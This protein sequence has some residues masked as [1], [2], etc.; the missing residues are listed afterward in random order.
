M[1]GTV[2]DPPLIEEVDERAAR[3]SVADT[4]ADI[5]R[6]LGVPMVVFVYR[7][8][9]ATT[10]RLERVWKLLAPNLASVEAQRIAATLDPPG[11]WKITPLPQE[12][13]EG[14]GIGPP[15]LASTLD[16]F[17]RANRLNL[18]G[19]QALLDGTL[20]DHDADRREAPS[21][22]PREVL[23]IADLAALEPDTIALL[24]RMSAPVAGSEQPILIPSLYRYF[25]HDRDLLETIWQSI[26]PAV[27]TE[28]FHDV[29]AAI[30]A[31]AR[32][33]SRRLPYAVP[34]ADDRGTRDI[35]TR[36]VTTIPGMI[37]TTKL[38]RHAFREQL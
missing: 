11:R 23:P 13:L 30:T 28:H 3:G 1:I 25:A 32:D 37:V 2:T 10:G 22:E 7:A 29:V 20:G 9:A 5:R 4:Y 21:P 15:C 36:F 18:L 31:R 33:H 14:A 16:G 17:D 19:L 6:V 26:G 24:Q 12:A 35:T 27:E 34:R 8:L 38:L